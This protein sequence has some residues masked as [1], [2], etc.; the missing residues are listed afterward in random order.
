MRS[1]GKAGVIVASLH[2]QK[3]QPANDLTV[4]SRANIAGSNFD[5][6]APDKPGNA[7]NLRPTR[8]SSRRRDCGRD[9][10]TCPG[11]DTTFPE[12]ETG[13]FPAAMAGV[14]QRSLQM[15]RRTEPDLDAC[16]GRFKLPSNQTIGKTPFRL[17]R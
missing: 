10:E 8:T 12:C 17:T 16:Q 15:G 2:L 14:C 1:Q 13:G 6:R 5:K 9:L 4:S 11:Q 7:G 3:S